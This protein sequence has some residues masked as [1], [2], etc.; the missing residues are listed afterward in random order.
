MAD[1]IDRVQKIK[2]KGEQLDLPVF[3]PDAT[4]GVIRSLD[5][6]D[7]ENTQTKG[8]IVNTYHLLSQPGTEALSEIGGI[9]NLMGWNN[10]IISDSGGFQMFSLI[11][12][13]PSLGK[14][15]QDGV[16]FN[17]HTKGGRKKYLI[18]P[19]KC[20]QIQFDIGSDI[21]IVLDYFTPF[22]ADD[23]L[24]KR[25]V[26]WTIEWA[27]RCKEE[28]E[29]QCEI[30]GLDENSKPLLFGV[31]QG[32]HSKSERERCAVELEKIGFDGYGLGGWTFNDK[33]EIDLEIIE[34]IAKVTP[35]TKPRYG[36][37]IGSPQSVVDCVRLGY[38]IFDCVL[39][40]R[41][42]R[43]ERLYVFNKNPDE[44][45]DIFNEKD[46][47]SYLYITREKHSRENAPISEYCD[48]HTCQ[49][50][51]RA[52]LHHLFRIGDSLAWRLCTIHNLR[53]YSKVMEL[54]A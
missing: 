26:D 33:N 22:K 23:L 21:M 7:L 17:L 4:R 30:R 43:H 14:I 1:M 38:G 9:K 50:Y 8:L 54:C 46:W 15:T 49:N 45:K 12:K 51:S 37:G 32:A 18:T 28:F 52:Y 6:Q 13:N 31:V 5:S 48:C 40:T 44:I 36:L 25:S 42:A 29:K 10:T 2:V 3:Y 39:P 47:Y 11:Q 19:E 53:M 34:H 41:D 16:T 35:G 27:K 24:I 20:I